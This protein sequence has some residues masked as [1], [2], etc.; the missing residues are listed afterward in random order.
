L[1]CDAELSVVFDWRSV[2]GEKDLIV[3]FFFGHSLVSHADL[4]FWLHFNPDHT[5]LS[6][7]MT[8]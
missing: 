1:L 6:A 3:V 7:A 2:I 5:V 8:D 4:S